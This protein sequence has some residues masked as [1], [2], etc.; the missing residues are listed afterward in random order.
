MENQSK[1]QIIILEDKALKEIIQKIDSTNYLIKED[2]KKRLLSELWIDAVDTCAALK[3]SRRTLSDYTQR[4]V[5]GHTKIS[6]KPYYS[7]QEILKKLDENY[8]SPKSK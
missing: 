8:V 7:V 5:L 3:I 4:G 6:G 2:K 1:Q